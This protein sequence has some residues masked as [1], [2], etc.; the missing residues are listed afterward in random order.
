MTDR[1]LDEQDKEYFS[2]R[3][4]VQKKVADM[5]Q[6]VYESELKRVQ[7]QVVNFSS[8]KSINVRVFDQ[9]SVVLKWGAAENSMG[10]QYRI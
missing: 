9:F 5:S 8:R 6:N 4:D 2:W 10:G 1:F 7:D 3:N